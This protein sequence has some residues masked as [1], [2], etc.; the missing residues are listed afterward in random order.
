[1]SG[2]ERLPRLPLADGDHNAQVAEGRHV[3]FFNLSSI[4]LAI[5]KLC[6]VERVVIALRTIVGFKSF[7]TFFFCRCAS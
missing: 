2:Q 3:N 6:A 4:A 7:A 1:M 5:G